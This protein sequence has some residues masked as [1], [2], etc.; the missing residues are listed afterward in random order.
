MLISGL[1]FLTSSTEAARASTLILGKA[2]PESKVNVPPT[3]EEV[4]KLESVRF[5]L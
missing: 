5:L 2:K 4:I 3:A 1:F